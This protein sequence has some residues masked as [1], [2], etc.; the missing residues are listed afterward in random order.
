MGGVSAQPFRLLNRSVTFFGARFPAVAF[1]IAA[2][3]LAA[4]IVA[5]VAE[6]MGVH[7]LQLVGL[8]PAGVLRGEV[9]RLLTW[10][11]FEPAPLSLI[12]ACAVLLFFGR[13]LCYYWGPARYLKI[14]AGFAVGTGAA[15]CL[16]GLVWPAVRSAHY[17]TAWAL[18]DAL[19]VAWATAFP[20]RQILVY[21]VLPLGGR[22][23]IYATVGI[24]V[25]FA[26][27]AGVA[28]F[29]PHFIAMGAMW[30]YQSGGMGGLWGRLRGGGGWNAAGPRRRSNL[31]VIDRRERRDEPPRWL[32]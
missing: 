3:T 22:R 32:H 27:F 16:V 28:L 12:F 9:W 29:V 10:P 6:G 19:I 2:G 24:N 21:F 26:L 4:T 5:V 20:S 18:A 25:I 11:L 13:D 23:L 7:L 1:L 8:H 31:R 14:F 17:L 30:A 15:V